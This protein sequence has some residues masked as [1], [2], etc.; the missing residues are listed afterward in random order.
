MKETLCFEGGS[1]LQKE[2][3]ALMLIVLLMVFRA[4]ILIFEGKGSQEL[5]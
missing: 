3:E 1:G 5:R 2:P 4:A